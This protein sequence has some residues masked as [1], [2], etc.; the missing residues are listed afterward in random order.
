MDTVTMLYSG[1][2]VKAQCAEDPQTGKRTVY[3]T[4]GDNLFEMSVGM[5]SEVSG[6]VTHAIERSNEVMA[7]KRSITANKKRKEA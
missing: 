7:A 2:N 4:L 5:W 3:L 6:K 1:S